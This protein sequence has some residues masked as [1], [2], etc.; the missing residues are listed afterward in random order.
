MRTLRT[1]KIDQ[2]LQ[3]DLTQYGLVRAIAEKAA[4]VD[5]DSPNFFGLREKGQEVELIF[6]DKKELLEPGVQVSVAV[7]E[8][9][10]FDMLATEDFSEAVKKADPKTLREFITK[11]LD[12][13]QV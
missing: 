2:T 4:P 12:D 9:E 13:I 5:T 10:P 6:N 3:E 8:I 1:T 7:P 11:L